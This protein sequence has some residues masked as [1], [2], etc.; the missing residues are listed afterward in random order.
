MSSVLQ[1][2]VI[3]A[4]IS[5]LS[6]AAA[7]DNNPFAALGTLF[8]TATFPEVRESLKVNL[9]MMLARST[10]PGA[11]PSERGAMPESPLTALALTMPYLPKLLPMET[12]EPQLI[13]GLE[14][15]F[16]EEA[17]RDNLATVQ[18]E[19][20]K[21]KGKDRAVFRAYV[22]KAAKEY[23]LTLQAMPQ[24][25]AHEVMIEQLNRKVD[26]KIGELREAFVSRDQ[27]L[28]TEFFVNRLFE[29]PGTYEAE[30]LPGTQAR[31]REFLYWRSEDLPARTRLYSTIKSE[32]EAAWKFEEARKL[33]REEAERLEAEI[34]KEKRTPAD[35]ERL[36]IEKK[37]GDLFELDTIAQLVPPAREVQPMAR[38]DYL[39]YEV[40][41]SK[42]EQL[43]YPPADLVKQLLKLKRPGEATVIADLPAKRFYVAVLLNRAEPTVKEFEMLYKSPPLGDTLFNRF[44]AMQTTEFRKSVMDQLRRDAAGEKKVDKD[45]RFVLPEEYRK[46]VEGGGRGDLE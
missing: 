30:Q 31:R 32:V 6:A 19:L 18:A 46:R 41:S 22:E 38:V 34:N 45:G 26:L 7:G 14:N 21:L 11:F 24:P 8:A 13:T 12:L 28:N 43:T 23:H 15:R 16:A 27:S 25:L 4:S 37:F 5:S 36:L 35:V 44:S 2:D 40:P 1:P 3:A 17:L 9:A 10:S 39:P 20:A 29:R 42:K 33:A